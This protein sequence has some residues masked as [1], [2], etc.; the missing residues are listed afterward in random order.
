MECRRLLGEE[1]EKETGEPILRGDDEFGD[2]VVREAMTSEEG[3][4]AFDE[5]EVEALFEEEVGR[6]KREAVRVKRVE[7]ENYRAES[8]KSAESAESAEIPTAFIYI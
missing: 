8:A 6:L 4:E 5:Y 1:A 3:G 7:R 2:G